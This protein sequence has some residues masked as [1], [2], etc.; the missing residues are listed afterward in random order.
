MWTEFE[1]TLTPL[2]EFLGIPMVILT[3]LAIILY[4]LLKVII[5]NML[6]KNSKSTGLIVANIIAQMFGEGEDLIQGVNELDTVKLIKQLPLEVQ[7]A[8]T[9]ISDVIKS[10]TEENDKKL[11][12]VYN[13]TTTKLN[14]VGELMGLLSQAMMSERLLKP[15]SS[16]ALRQIYAKATSM[17]DDKTTLTDILAQAKEAQVVVK[18][19]VNVID[20]AKEISEAIVDLFDGDDNITKEV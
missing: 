19:I 2:F 13:I 15:Q 1:E 16:T 9:S 20:D 18:N 14:E 17:I 7:N 11:V 3:P 4:V 6:K 5:P 10:N 8:I 12:A